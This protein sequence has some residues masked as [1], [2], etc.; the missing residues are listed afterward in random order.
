M[1]D[2][3]IR[4]KKTK[5]IHCQQACSN[6]NAKSVFQMEDKFYQRETW[7]VG[8]EGRATEML[9]IWEN[10]IDSFS[11]HKLKKIY[12]IVESMSDGVTTSTDLMTTKHKRRRVK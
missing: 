2:D 12:M 11:P 3:E 7:N 1:N 10:I 5:R 4:I 6:R 8:S 9:N